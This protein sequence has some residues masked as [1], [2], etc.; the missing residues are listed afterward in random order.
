MGKFDTVGAI[1]GAAGGY[2]TGGPIGAVAGGL[3]GGFASAGS[4]GGS[5][6]NRTAIL[7][8]MLSLDAWN[9]QNKYNSPVEQMKRLRE[10]GLNPALVYGS[11]NV[12][13]NS[14]TSLQ[15][16]SLPYSSGVSSRDYSGLSK[17]VSR[18]FLAR[19][20]ESAQNQ[21]K[22]EMANEEA[23]RLDNDYKRG[24]LELQRLKI[25]S[26]QRAFGGP[27]KTPKVITPEEQETKRVEQQIKQSRQDKYQE[28]RIRDQYRSS[29]VGSLP[30]VGRPFADYLYERDYDWRLSKSRR[31]GGRSWES[32]SPLAL[33]GFG[34]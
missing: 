30:L 27:V 8:Y 3:L 2:A 25:A 17:A 1:E 20:M 32:R 34:L 14:S 19:Q 5:S 21:N 31:S 12:T 33:F 16:A 23:Q 7:N 26:L 4:S 24:R 18:F 29:F 6:G 13:G 11:G 9:R 15:P 28:D 22:I 10:A